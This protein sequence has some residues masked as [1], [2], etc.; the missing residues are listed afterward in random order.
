MCLFCDESWSS[1]KIVSLFSFHSILFAAPG[2]VTSFT[3]TPDI[4]SI[5]VSWEP[6]VSGEGRGHISQYEVCYRP[7]GSTFSPLCATLIGEDIKR[8]RIQ[9][10]QVE[11]AYSITVQAFI[12]SLAGPIQVIVARTSS[13]GK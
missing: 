4:I 10:L 9:G 1:L 7:V 3:G 2:E 6:P 12:E 13:I 5:T 8:Y 11:N